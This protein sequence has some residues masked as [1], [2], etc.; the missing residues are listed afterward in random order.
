MSGKSGDKAIQEQRIQENIGEKIRKFRTDKQMNTVTLAAR[1]GISQGQLSKIENG[2][3]TISIKNLTRL[4]S[5]LSVPLSLLFQQDGAPPE[6]PDVI[7]AVAG[8]ENQGLH[9][10]DREI[11]RHTDG[12]VTLKP[13]GPFQFGTASEQIQYGFGGHLD[14]FV[15]SIEQFQTMAPALRHLALPYSFRS[16]ENRQAFLNSSYFRE[17]VTDVLLSNGIRILNPNWNWLRGEQFVVLSKTPVISPEDVRGLRVRVYQS[18]AQTQFWKQMG[19]RPVTIGWWDVKDALKN[20]EVDVVPTMKALAYH[21][22]FCEF[23]RYI[24]LLG[25]IP[26]AL[27]V[28]MSE[29]KFR[30]F[31]LKSRPA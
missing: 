2:K 1:A 26:C 11:F 12:A 27:G 30:S 4:C 29:E 28:Y 21:N 25:D 16:E 17:Q 3:A 24:T 15:E 8:L 7:N 10:F 31:S 22:G 20:D 23:A 9:W 6:A 13:L 18:E 19:A 14:L 5:E